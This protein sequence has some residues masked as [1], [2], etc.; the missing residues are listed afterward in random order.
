[1]ASITI[2]TNAAQDA[3]LAPAY[4]DKLGLG[5][6]ATVAEVKAYLISVLQADVRNY[7]YEQAK[8]AIA[9]ADFEPG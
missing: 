4:G 5:R 3:R 7:E 9:T 1:M 8:Q 6:N 2:T